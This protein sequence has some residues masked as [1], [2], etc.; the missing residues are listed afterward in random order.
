M[1]GPV[2]DGAF[3]NSTFA[4]RS[5]K[6]AAYKARQGPMKSVF[7]EAGGQQQKVTRTTPKEFR[8]VAKSFVSSLRDQLGEN[9]V[10][11]LAANQVA[12]PVL[13]VRPNFL[14]DL[15]VIYM[16]L[17]MLLELEAAFHMSDT[18]GSL[19]DHVLV[20]LIALLREC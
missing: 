7:A 10:R 4:V 11:A 18:P 9:E 19:M 5:K 16:R 2:D 13:Q 1:L 12:S 14:R 17:Q 6:S 20:G 8:K 15:D 3:H